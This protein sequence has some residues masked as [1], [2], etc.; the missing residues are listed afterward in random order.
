V[1]T[2]EAKTMQYGALMTEQALAAM[3][4]SW[5]VWPSMPARVVE[6]MGRRLGGPVVIYHWRND[7]VVVDADSLGEEGRQRAWGRQGVARR[8]K[9]Y[10]P[11]NLGPDADRVVSGEE[12]RVRDSKHWARF[13][14]TMLRPLGLGDQVRSLVTGDEGRFMAF[15]GAYTA[16]GRNA[17]GAML[18]AFERLLPPVSERL[19]M[20]KLL[21]EASPDRLAVLELVGELS[22]PAFIVGEDGAVL[23]ANLAARFAYDRSPEWLPSACLQSSPPSWLRRIPI[24]DGPRRVYVCLPRTPALGVERLGAW[25]AKHW[26]LPP[27]LHAT[28]AKLIAGDSD[29][30]I[31]RDTGLRFATVRT[32][33]QQ[34]YRHVGVSSRT[35]LLRE[36]LRVLWS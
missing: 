36:A 34:I 14:E 20:W 17:E 31:V 21:A 2:K 4:E 7:D 18:D 24:T 32:Y 19:R 25:A 28:A 10:D 5:D 3:D 12:L 15:V 22:K 16:R 23:F 27:R 11:A 13:D 33:V 26:G 35:A 30:Q 1:S 29:K 9:M 8:L 6:V